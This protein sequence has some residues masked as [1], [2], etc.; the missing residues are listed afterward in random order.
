MLNEE[1]LEIVSEVF[2][3]VIEKMAFMF[4]ENVA[5]TDLPMS[6]QRY[7][8]AQMSFDGER[9]G[10][11]CMAVPVEMCIEVAANVL[12]VDPDDDFA[13]DESCDALK[14]VLN[15]TCGNLLTALA[16]E[17][18]VFNLHP[19]E[20]SE[21]DEAGWQALLEEEGSIAFNVDENPV[22]LHLKY[23]I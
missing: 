1:Q 19:P 21:L 7:F 5:A 22:L 17:E 6:S 9:E 14:E 23:G 8:L 2:C 4:G 11:L 3:D 20:V 16:G 12:G 13:Q 18:P 15:V 10:V